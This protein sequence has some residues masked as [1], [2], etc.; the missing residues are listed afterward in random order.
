MTE[1]DEH[2]EAKSEKLTDGEMVERV[3]HPTGASE[4][5]REE[6]ADPDG[7]PVQTPDR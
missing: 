6:G 1:R 3:A 4:D 2:V 5:A 7:P